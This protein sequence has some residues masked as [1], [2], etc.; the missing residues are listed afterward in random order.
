MFLD[1]YIMYLYAYQWRIQDLEKGG[2]S[3]HV[4]DVIKCAKRALGGVACGVCSTWG[5]MS[6]LRS[7]WCCFGVKQQE[8]DD[9]LPM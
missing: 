9:Q 3:V 4:T 5:T 7:F 2:P 6:H 8:L 1:I